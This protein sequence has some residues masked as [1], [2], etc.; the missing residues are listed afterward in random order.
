MNLEAIHS[1]IWYHTTDAYHGAGSLQKIASLNALAIRSKTELMGTVQL[2]V[3][4]CRCWPF[5]HSPFW[6]QLQ[7]EYPSIETNGDDAL[8][9]LTI[10][11]PFDC[12][13]FKFQFSA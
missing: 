1:E 3:I 2:L 8:P 12:I 4:K 10:T 7:A 9:L 13:K 11:D 5:K 6:F